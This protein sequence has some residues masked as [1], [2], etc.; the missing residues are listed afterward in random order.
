[1]HPLVNDMDIARKLADI[2]FTEYEPFI[3]MNRNE[4]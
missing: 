1:M 4:F 2:F 3:S